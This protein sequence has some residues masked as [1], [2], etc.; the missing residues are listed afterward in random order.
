VLGLSEETVELPARGVEGALLIFPDVMD[1][2]PA[3]LVD[4][5]ADE[6]FDG[7]LSQSRVFVHV[8]DDLSAE[9]PHIVDMV[10]DGPFRQARLGKVKEE[11]HE[12]FHEFSAGRKFLFLAT[13]PGFVYGRASFAEAGLDS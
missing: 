2:R 4:Y 8:A 12:V 13:I 10:L 7:Y 3:V 1:Q 5:I 9:Q 6:L 11:G